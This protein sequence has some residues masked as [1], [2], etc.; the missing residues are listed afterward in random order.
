M[1]IRNAAYIYK[2]LPNMSKNNLKFDIKE[3]HWEKKIGKLF[4]L[5]Y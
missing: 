4:A 1:Y 2:I 3:P 5:Y